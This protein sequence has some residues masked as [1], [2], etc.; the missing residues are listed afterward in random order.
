MERRKEKK[1]TDTKRP[2]EA[3]RAKKKKEDNNN[4]REGQRRGQRQCSMRTVH[5]E[6]HRKEYAHAS[7]LISGHFHV[8]QLYEK[9]KG[10]KKRELKEE[11][12]RLAY[13]VFLFFF[14]APFPLSSLFSSPCYSEAFKRK[15]KNSSKS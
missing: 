12:P 3:K 7:L 15:K 1:S 11:K 10:G 4:I 2:T 5:P 13:I 8:S 14:L 9:R 6:T